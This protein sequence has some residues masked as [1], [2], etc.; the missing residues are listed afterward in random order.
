[1]T[2]IYNFLPLLLLFQNCMAQKNYVTTRTVNSKVRTIYDRSV[3]MSS[4][5]QYDA[6]LVD[7]E[8]ALKLEPTFID[9]QIE[10]ANIKNQFG[11]Y[12]EAEQGYERCWQ[13]TPPTCREFYSVLALWNTTRV[14]SAK[15]PGISKPISKPPESAKSAAGAADIISPRHSLL[16]RHTATPCLMSRRTSARTPI[17]P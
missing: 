16:K 10:W 13:L 17:P 14:S 12:A 15:P 1:M 8:K 7:L 11:Q 5:H 9:A 3:R 6:A 4:L 2:R